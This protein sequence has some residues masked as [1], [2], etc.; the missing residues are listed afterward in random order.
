MIWFDNGGL[1]GM[2]K[3]IKILLAILLVSQFL[4]VSYAQA[5]FTLNVG[6]IYTYD[7]KDSWWIY[8]VGEDESL[9]TGFRFNDEH[10]FCDE[11]ILVTVAYVD[12]ITAEFNVSI[13]DYSG[14]FGI[15]PMQMFGFVSLLQHP[16]DILVGVS[17]WIISEEP[18]YLELKHMYHFNP[19]QWD[20]FFELLEDEDF[21]AEEYP[22]DE[23]TTY[24]DVGGDFDDSGDIAVLDWVMDAETID[25]D[26]GTNYGGTYSLTI[27]YDLT[28]G[29]LQRYQIDFHYAG[30]YEHTTVDLSSHQEI[31]LKETNPTNNSPG[32]LAIL[33]IQVFTGLGLY[34]LLKRKKKC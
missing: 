7:V 33:A 26:H 3:R 31:E 20:D 25:E 23:H 28:T 12:Y 1:K 21:I 27:E 22:N 32:F 17:N 11:D 4:G 34:N 24:S 9:G 6:D 8:Y 15:T 14:T 13:G 16:A 2:Y 19:S 18:L 10:Y 29:M 30:T 5:S